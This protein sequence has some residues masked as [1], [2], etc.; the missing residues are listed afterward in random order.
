[1]IVVNIYEV[2]TANISEFQFFF[3]SVNNRDMYNID[4]ENSSN[5]SDYRLQKIRGK[6]IVLVES[7][8]PWYLNKDD[9]I[10]IPYNKNIRLTNKQYREN[11]DYGS[12]ENSNKEYFDTK[13]TCGQNQIILLLFILLVLLFVCKKYYQ[14]KL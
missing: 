13:Q 14:R 5:N 10:Q 12:Y 6:T 3:I 4:T 7:D 2:K 11:A 1:M 9:T 8:N